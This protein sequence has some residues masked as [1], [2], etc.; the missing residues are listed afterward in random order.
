MQEVVAPINHL[1]DQIADEEHAFTYLRP[2]YG[3]GLSTNWCA[4][5]FCCPSI[6][7]LSP[8]FCCRSYPPP[9]LPPDNVICYTILLAMETRMWPPITAII[10]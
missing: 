2:W 3:F 7:L 10:N 6:L 9:P 4:G 5:G 1:F 8:T